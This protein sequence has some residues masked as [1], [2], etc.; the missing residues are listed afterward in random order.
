MKLGNSS[1]LSDMNQTASLAQDRIQLT[2]KRM[3]FDAKASGFGKADRHSSI[4]GGTR[5]AGPIV[6]EQITQE[7]SFQGSA[8]KCWPKWSVPHVVYLQQVQHKLGGCVDGKETSTADLVLQAR[9]QSLTQ[10]Y[11]ARTTLRRDLCTCKPSVYSMS[12]SFLNL[13]MKKLTRD[14]VVPTISASVS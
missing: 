9:L 10:R 6:E 12:P 1:E 11:A 3:S 8:M 13:F 14:R 7:R 2:A 5:D 4:R